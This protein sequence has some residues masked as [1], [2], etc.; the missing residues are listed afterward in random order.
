MATK[1]RRRQTA[2]KAECHQEPGGAPCTIETSVSDHDDISDYNAEVSLMSIHNSTISFKHDDVQNEPDDALRNLGH[3]RDC[4]NNGR[5]Y[6][7]NQQSQDSQVSVENQC[8]QSGHSQNR[9]NN[10]RQYEYNQQSQD[11]QVSVENQCRQSGHSQNQ[12]DVIYKGGSDEGQCYMQSQCSKAPIENTCTQPSQRQ[13]LSTSGSVSTCQ[14]QSSSSP[15]RSGVQ[16]G[17]V[18]K[19]CPGTRKN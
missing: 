18:Q 11:S 1:G 2:P 3:T 16:Y 7:Y 12:T 15:A 19:Q 5:Q 14:N 9:G 10:G 4:G 17:D 8:R 6:E 13:N